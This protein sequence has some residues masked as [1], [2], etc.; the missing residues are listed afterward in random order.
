M[1]AWDD[2]RVLLAISRCG[3]FVAA[4]QRLG[5]STATV[6]RQAKA[7]EER[8]GTLLYRRDTTGVSLTPAGREAAIVAEE[9]EEAINSLEARVSNESNFAQGVIRLATVDTLIAGPLMA[10]IRKFADENPLITLD[11]QSGVTMTN[12]RQREADAALRAGGEPPDGLVG[13]RLARISVAVYTARHGVPITEDEYA[14]ANWVVPDDQLDHLA[15][16]RWLRHQ[17]YDRR[18]V[19]KANSLH[20]LA[21]GVAAGVG[22]GILPCYLADTDMRLQRIGNPIDPLAGDL[23]FLT[24][25][26]LRGTTRVRALSDFMA[27][28]ITRLRPLFA[29]LLPNSSR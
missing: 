12:I 19:M 17:G 22:L 23:W 5:V 28:E 21:M 8:L 24:H 14:Q 7:A 2:L 6:L 1:L 18:A 9:I 4:S 16:A 10:L 3:T 26:E 20:T 27:K 25:P 15:S 11:I 13:R 29:G